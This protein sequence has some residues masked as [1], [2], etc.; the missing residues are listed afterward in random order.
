MEM[1][2]TARTL[3]LLRAG[4]VTPLDCALNG[5]CLSLSQRVGDLRRAGW[6]IL[7]GWRVLPSG[8][9]VKEYTVISGP[10]L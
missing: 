3:E 1:T 8:A 9:R 4:W 10:S 5:G 2:K 7:D 6:G